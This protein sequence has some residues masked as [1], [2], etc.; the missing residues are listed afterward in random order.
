MGGDLV[1]LFGA[2]LL[3]SAHCVAMCG[4]YVT[5]CTAHFVP[6]GASPGVRCGL[7]LLFNIGRVATYGMIG[8]IVGAFGQ[9]AEAAAARLGLSGIIAILAGAAALAFGLSMI[10]WI[11]DPARV[12][13]KAG[14]GRL[15]AAG[16]MR[17]HRVP[18]AAAPLLL[19]ALQGWLPCALVYAAASRASLAGTP[20]MGAV[21]MLVFGLGT[22][23]AVF[24]LT[25]IP[26]AVLRRVQA[27]RLAGALLA[28]LGV[29][30]IL[31]GLA[32]F[33]WVPSTGWW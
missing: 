6:R 7:R 14:L 23:P 33:G 11:R 2:S 9:I 12:V 22:V 15:L 31:R 8:L 5:M 18:T 16:R 25:L 27:Q 32:N 17:L 13:A 3:G 24:A 30:L 28:A 20:I 21:T 26:Q 29:L 10:G 19:G 1:L 4:P